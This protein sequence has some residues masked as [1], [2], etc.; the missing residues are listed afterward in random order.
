MT[1][2]ITL[3]TIELCTS[4]KVRDLEP[5]LNFTGLLGGNFATSLPYCYQFYKS[6]IDTEKTRFESYDGLGEI[7]IAFLFN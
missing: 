4:R 1:T 3:L 5:W 2:K 6:I 7:M